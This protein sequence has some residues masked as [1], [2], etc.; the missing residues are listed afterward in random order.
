MPV[1]LFT[2][3]AAIEG[4]DGQLKTAAK[5][6]GHEPEMGQMDAGGVTSGLGQ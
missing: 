3:L 2:A 5:K 4:E 1:D 6:L